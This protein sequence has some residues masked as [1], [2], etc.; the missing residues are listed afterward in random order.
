MWHALSKEEVLEKL[1]TSTNGLS[2]KEARKRLEVYGS[3]EIEEKKK[4]N[5]FLIFL[6]Q[7]NSFF[8][9]LLMIA[10]FISLLFSRFLD[11]FTI[12]AI[13]I[14]NASLGFI[15]NYKAEKAIEALKKRLVQKAKVIRDG[16]LHEINAVEVVPG[17]LIV[18]EEGDKVVA[19]A[20]IIES[21]ELQTNEAVLTGESLPVDKTSK[22]IKED[23]PLFERKNMVYCGT[24]VVRGNCKAIV[25]AT[26]M[27]T[28]FGKIAEKLGEIKK[29]KTPLQKK[30]D[31]FAKKIGIFVIFLAFIL[32][33]VGISLGVDKIMML[34]TSISLAVAAVPEGLPA[35]VTI[36]LAIAVNRM[37]KV[38]NLIRRLPS[39]ETLGRVTVI[40]SDKTGT[41]TTGNMEVVEFF[42]DNK[43]R[44]IKGIKKEIRKS[45]SGEMLLKTA[46][47]CNNAK[48]KKTNN[49]PMFF[50]DPTEQALLRSGIK[51]YG[52]QFVQ[53]I[54][55]EQRVKEFPFTS[56]RKL[57]SVIVKDKNCFIS[58]VKGAPEVILERCSY[59]FIEGKYRKLDKKRK[60]ELLAA[61]EKMANDGLRVLAFAFKKLR[62]E[63]K[64]KQNDAEFDLVFVGF[65][66]MLDPPRPEVKPAI[67][68]CKEAG[69]DVKMIT[70]DSAITAKAIAKK[71]GLSG[72]LLTGEEIDKM[73]DEELKQRLKDI[74]IFARVS[75]EH[76]L[77]I[78]TLLKEMGEIVAVTGDG[79]NDAPALKKAD[80][81]IAMG[82]RGT[83]VA[84]NTSDIVL[85]DDNFASIVNGVKEGRRVF[86]NIKKFSY[87]LLSS[88][89]A[90]IFIIAFALFFGLKLGLP[91]ILILLPIQ[92][93]WVNL[94]TDGIIAIALGYE[95]FEKDV[96]K[97]KPEK[98]EI[99]TLNILAIWILL[100][101]VVSVGTFLLFKLLNVKD[102]IKMQT[103]AFTS[104]VFF[105]AFN[106]LNFRSFKEQIYKLR[107]NVW[108]IFAI[109]VSFILQIIIV[110]ISF[111]QKIFGTTSLSFKE[112]FL[113]FLISSSILILGELFKYTKAKIMKK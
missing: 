71:I 92:I 64:I 50:G 57:M 51:I 73:D 91:S 83:D 84:R 3:N 33:F 108:L 6:S 35:V 44:D 69:I 100:A 25:V 93:L 34:L 94:V 105:E 61:Y 113:I 40:C 28:E 53:E 49:K 12:F 29:E 70:G 46:I 107:M 106:A 37:Y 16:V 111:F 5:P 72:N 15:Q 47:L 30:L 45:K 43:T 21:Y 68:A 110:K 96:M 85:I 82:Q 13:I 87:F 59:E 14:L 20:R 17:D 78:V 103:V 74:K 102:A 81:S 97:R 101:V 66:G 88:N 56:A 39:A 31:D 22:K 109:L 89:L 2:E 58:Y 76:K 32:A 36:T 104:L 19:D 52:F 60:S 42:F 79:V 55:K 23:S 26:G 38:K 8:V 98:G 112:I 4:I 27:K 86:D 65:Q 90:E 54:L 75:P 99:F 63:K 95:G 10:A 18:L 62:K 41:M 7:F 80:I 67:K 77:K 9:Y 24:E 11:F 1:E 48:V